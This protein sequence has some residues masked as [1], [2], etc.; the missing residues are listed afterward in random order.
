MNLSLFSVSLGW[1]NCQSLLLKQEQLDSGTAFS[2]LFYRL[3]HHP[4]VYKHIHKIHHE[5][6]APIG[7]IGIYAHPLEHLISNLTPIFS[8]PLLMGSHIAT[9]WLWFCL[10]YMSTIIS[11][12]GYHFP[13]LPSPE[14]HDF[15]HLK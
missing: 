8:G 9:F 1:C 10:A 3:A 4:R 15:H 5:W 13:F 11:H 14:A 7:I 2:L 6:T 12:S